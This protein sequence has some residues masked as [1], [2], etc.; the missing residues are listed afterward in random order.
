MK[1][2]EHLLQVFAHRERPKHFTNYK[3]C[4]DCK[5][6]DDLLSSHTPDTISF[7][8]LG[9]I[10]WNPI[11]SISKDGFL[12]YLPALARLALG[13]GDEYFIDQ[14]LI[15]VDQKERLDSMTLE[16]KDA[17]RSF[18]MHLGKAMS[19]EILNNLDAEDFDNL[20]TKLS[21]KYRGSS[22]ES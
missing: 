2:Y 20:L 17:L 14:F 19:N 5:E 18:L 12:Y 16:E 10:A 15:H 7:K 6:F 9:N 3:H 4:D 8:E 1:L 11:S 13:K 21:T 22:L